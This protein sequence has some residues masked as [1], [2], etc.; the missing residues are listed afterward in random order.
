MS[1]SPES[2]EP[3][4]SEIGNAIKFQEHNI[5]CLRIIVRLIQAPEFLVKC[6]SPWEL[7]QHLELLV[8]GSGNVAV[9]NDL[10]YIWRRSKFWPQTFTNDSYK[11]PKV[12]GFYLDLLPL[13]VILPEEIRVV[14]NR[15]Y[16]ESAYGQLTD[17]WWPKEQSCR[18]TFRL[19]HP[20][21]KKEFMV[22]YSWAANG[23]NKKCEE[24]TF[25]DLEL[26]GWS[27]GCNPTWLISPFWSCAYRSQI[28]KNLKRLELLCPG[29][30]PALIK[31]LA[32]RNKRLSG[33]YVL[34]IFD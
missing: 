33:E 27:L 24:F 15:I 1:K 18:R 4:K 12:W 30:Y 26:M 32:A 11:S 5:S 20:L 3:G 22:R 29:P 10:A 6:N 9:L 17:L 2:S 23:D 14:L 13:N 8:N 21:F 31:S 28:S 25:D 7:C 34:S 16:N 19:L